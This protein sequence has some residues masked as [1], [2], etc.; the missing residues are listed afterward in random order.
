MIQD[1]TRKNA[2]CKALY[3]T[4]RMTHQTHL[5]LTDPS[6]T[7][8]GCGHTTIAVSSKGFTNFLHSLLMPLISLLMM[9]WLKGRAV[10]RDTSGSRG[11][12]TR[13]QS[14]SHRTARRT[15]Q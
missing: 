7:N 14:G 15:R 3:M 5:W 12:D 6:S 11:S 9:I 2:R 8:Q 10:Q 4:G 13:C 1:Y